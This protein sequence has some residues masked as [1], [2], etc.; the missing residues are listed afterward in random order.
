MGVGVVT[1]KQAMDWAFSGV[2]LRGS[3]VPWD[4]RKDQPYE[5]YDQVRVR[6]GLAICSQAFTAA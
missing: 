4:L 5:I 3:G 1:A 2:M 6:R